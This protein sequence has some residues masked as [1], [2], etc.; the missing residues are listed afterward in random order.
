MIIGGKVK[1][2]FGRYR[3]SSMLLAINSVDTAVYAFSGA[4][5]RFIVIAFIIR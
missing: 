1:E 2:G 4:S 3:T 5:T